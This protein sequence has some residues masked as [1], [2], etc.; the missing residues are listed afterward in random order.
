[1]LL[2]MMKISYQIRELGARHLTHMRR[3]HP[4][5]EMKKTDAGYER[6]KRRYG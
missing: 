3:S 2:E 4:H 5:P 1:M 6:S